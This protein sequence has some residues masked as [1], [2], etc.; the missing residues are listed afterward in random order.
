M[1]PRSRT[2][3]PPVSAWF[4]ASMRKILSDGNYSGRSVMDAIRQC[5][6]WLVA[7]G[8]FSP[9]LRASPFE[10][11]PG[12]GFRCVPPPPRRYDPPWGFIRRMNFVEPQSQRAPASVHVGDK[13]WSQARDSHMT[14][15]AIH[16][17]PAAG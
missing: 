2:A 6:G 14:S 3:L 1:G 17:E 16:R 10:A 7:S 4:T 8:I 11:L 5:L 13:L 15:A 12:V 9:N